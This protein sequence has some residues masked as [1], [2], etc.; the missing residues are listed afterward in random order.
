MNKAKTTI[1]LCFMFALTF[2]IYG[3]ET[4]IAPL[5]DKYKVPTDVRMF[6]KAKW[7]TR[8][9]DFIRYSGEIE[10][11]DA[12]I[13]K[14]FEDIE[15]WEG[16]FFTGK[17]STWYNFRND[18]YSISFYI[19]NDKVVESKI[20]PGF[21]T[22]ETLTDMWIPERGTI[23][24]KTKKPYIV[25]P[26]D[27]R[28]EIKAVANAIN[29]ALRAF[30]TPKPVTPPEK[31]AGRIYNSVFV[32]NWDM[33]SEGN[34]TDF[35]KKT[36]GKIKPDATL[37]EVFAMAEWDVVSCLA[38]VWDIG[39]P[40]DQGRGGGAVGGSKCSPDGMMMDPRTFAQDHGTIM[41]VYNIYPYS[42]LPEKQR[43]AVKQ[44]ADNMVY[45]RWVRLLN[46]WAG[47]TIGLLQ[48]K[49]ND[50][51]YTAQEKEQWKMM[52]QVVKA[53]N[54]AKQKDF[55]SMLCPFDPS[56]QVEE[57]L[58]EFLKMQYELFDESLRTKSY[59][60]FSSGEYRHLLMRE[61][62][63]NAGAKIEQREMCFYWVA[64]EY[65]AMTKRGKQVG[66]VYFV[67]K[68]TCPKWDRRVFCIQK[69]VCP[70]LWAT[71]RD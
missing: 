32:L 40:T 61:Y 66:Q 39:S 5:P 17:L 18:L 16:E 24:P 58:R 28:L 49:Q 56:L 31:S 63:L 53:F 4:K 62:E 3:N 30:D 35:L 8:I 60:P 64:S 37:E 57:R 68:I 33:K 26:E 25:L 9:P 52:E 20:Y 55:N 48:K 54:D 12:G 50:S 47:R 13:Q 42:S 10:K 19:K 14:M 34:F 71:G 41:Q 7:D 21:V 15:G 45:G 67:F 11:M 44:D 65:L 43:K 69:I 2:V 38:E 29:M 27:T 22:P 51:Q 6:S 23:N 36:I 46:Q 70:I 59:P 1:F